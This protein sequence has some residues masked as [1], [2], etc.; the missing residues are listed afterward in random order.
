MRSRVLGNRLT[1]LLKEVRNPDTGHPSW[2]R[3]YSF[4][5]RAQMASIVNKLMKEPNWYEKRFDGVDGI[6]SDAE[7][8]EDPNSL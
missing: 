4:P 6:R 2:E 5:P 7:L 8:R 3:S 1:L